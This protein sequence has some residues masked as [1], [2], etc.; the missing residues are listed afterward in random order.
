MTNCAGKH[1]DLVLQMAR[2][3]LREPKIDK[4]LAYVYAK[5]DRLH[6]MEDFLCMTNVAD[7]FGGRREVFPGRAVPSRKAPLH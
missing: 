5:T 2:K 7:I 1:D 6:D 3:H 4:E